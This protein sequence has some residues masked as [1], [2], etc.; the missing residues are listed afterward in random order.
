[1]TYR[2][3][4]EQGCRTLQ[5][6]GIEEAALDARL[7]LEAV[8]GTDRNDLLVH[9]EQPVAPEAE[10]K[11][12]N[13]IR[14]RAEHIPLQ[15]LTGEQGFMGLTFSVNEHVLI[16]RQDTEILVEEVL[17]ELHDGMRVLDM[18]TG[19]GCILLS[20]L[21]YSNDCEGLGVDLSAEALEVAGRNV[22]KVLTPEKAEH[23]HFLQSDLFEKVEGKFEIIVSNPPY[24]ASAEVEKLM[25]EVRNH[26]P[27]MALD[28]TEDG[29][30]FYRRIIEEAGKHLVSSGMLFFEIG[31]DQGQAVSE[32]MRTEGY[33]DV[34]VV[35]DYAGLDRVVFGT[36]VT[37]QPAP[38]AKSR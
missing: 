6:A 33:C 1:M 20:L 29:L 15:Q 18:C 3:C 28:G 21:H 4:Y 19:S 24:I 16:P 34:Q 31:Y 37:V 12:L 13:W 17:K 14:Q 8:C 30:Y 10:E 27:R 26:E 38:F 36:Y 23:A 22:L 25:P 9:G 35:Q 11:Y 32:L 2:E 5:A 7:L